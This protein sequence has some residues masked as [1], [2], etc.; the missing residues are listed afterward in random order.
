ML[1][2]TEAM[3]KMHARH[4]KDYWDDEELKTPEY[5]VISLVP[6]FWNHMAFF[7]IVSQTFLAYQYFLESWHNNVKEETFKVTA[8]LER[9]SISASL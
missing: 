4:F 3:N 1:D 9:T 5:L 8:K 6:N 2:A 7:E